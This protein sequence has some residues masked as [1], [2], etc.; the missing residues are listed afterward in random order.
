MQ[1]NCGPACHSRTSVSRTHNESYYAISCY[2][3][4]QTQFNKQIS[5]GRW[6]AYSKGSIELCDKYSTFA[7]NGRSTLADAPKDVR[8]LEALKPSNTPS[9]RER[10]DAAVGK[11]KRL[12]VATQPLMKKQQQ[13]GGDEKNNKRKRKGGD[14][15]EGVDND[16]VVLDGDEK[17]KKSKPKGKKKKKAVVIEADLKN[18]GAL[19]EEDEVQEGI[20]W[21]DSDSE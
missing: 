14:K 13:Q 20:V 3:K 5:N 7:I 9:M 10:Y 19:D 4:P 15:E 6:R 2:H 21:S 8:R 18:I 17:E 11:E 16:D 1:D 12:E